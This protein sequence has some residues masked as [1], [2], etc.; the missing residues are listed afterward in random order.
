MIKMAD[1]A[2]NPIYKERRKSLSWVN[3]RHLGLEGRRNADAVNRYVDWYQPQLFAAVLFIV[4]CSILDAVLT[5]NI[6]S[7]G[8]RELNILMASLL[9]TGTQQFINIKM[10]LTGLSIIFLVIH[11]N[12][13]IYNNFLVGHF[14]YCIA[15]LYAGLIGYQILLLS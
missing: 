14:I 10:A 5:L 15:F 12:F 4:F 9:E 6:L 8:G 1:F 7:K 13:R 2:K 3:S 11:K